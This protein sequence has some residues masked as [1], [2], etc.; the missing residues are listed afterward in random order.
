MI[1]S[2]QQPIRRAKS[3]QFKQ[4][5]DDNPLKNFN[6]RHRQR[7]T[8]KVQNFIRQ[9]EM[10]LTYADLNGIWDEIK[11]L[12]NRTAPGSD[13]IHVPLIK[14]LPDTALLLLLIIINS[15]FLLS[16]FPKKWKHAKL[17][18]LRKPGKPEHTAPTYRP[19]SLLCV[20]SKILERIDLRRLTTHLENHNILPDS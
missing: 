20:F 4:N 19:I 1:L 13:Q 14:N 17:I 16:Y 6:R 18:P 12:K 15:C 11:R 8:A 3:Y 10:A 9:S 2:T 5:Y 7:T